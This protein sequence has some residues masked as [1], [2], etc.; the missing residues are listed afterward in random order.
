MSKKNPLGSDATDVFAP[1]SIVHEVVVERQQF[2]QEE[3][4][5]AVDIQRISFSEHNRLR[6]NGRVYGGYDKNG[7]FYAV[8]ISPYFEKFHTQID[9][10]IFPLVDAFRQKGYLTCSSCY[11]HPTR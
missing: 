8:S 9:P 2:Q 4:K 6:E 7:N 3:S 11:G 5:Q 1:S 10:G